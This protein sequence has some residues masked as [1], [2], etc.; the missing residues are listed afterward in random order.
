MKFEAFEVCFSG[1][2]KNLFFR[3]ISIHFATFLPLEKCENESNIFEI[4]LV[5]GFRPLKK[6]IT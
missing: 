4:I 2:N 6:K 1:S 5:Q 3:V